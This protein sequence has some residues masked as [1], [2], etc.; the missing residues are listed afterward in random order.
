M[1]YI[2]ELLEEKKAEIEAQ[3]GS[4]DSIDRAINRFRDTVEIKAIIQERKGQR[5]PTRQLE[6]ELAS[7]GEQ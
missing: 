6:D 5:K 4:T 3:G 7:R 1:N 2:K